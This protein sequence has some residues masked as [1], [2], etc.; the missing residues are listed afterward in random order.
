MTNT[1]MTEK[2]LTENPL[3]RPQLF[4]QHKPRSQHNT[5]YKSWTRDEGDGLHWVHRAELVDFRS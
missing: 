3:S 2:R 1:A 5:A 4:N